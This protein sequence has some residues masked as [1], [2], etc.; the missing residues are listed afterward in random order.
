[1]ENEGE[2]SGNCTVSE[3]PYSGNH[4]RRDAGTYRVFGLPRGTFRSLL[5]DAVSAGPDSK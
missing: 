5:V 1:M 4:T 3:W 2:R